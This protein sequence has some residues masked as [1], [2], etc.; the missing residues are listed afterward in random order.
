MTEELVLAEELAREAHAGQVDKSGRAYVHHLERVVSL[1]DG[2]QAQSVA[3]LH[4]VLEDTDITEDELLAE[5][6]SR[7]V[8]AAVQIVTRRAPWDYEEYI[9][10]IILSRNPLAIAV[11]RADLE[12]H[13]RPT[14]PP[15]LRGKYE[16]AWPLI[17][18][19]W[20]SLQR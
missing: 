12:D 7:D 10:R 9:R 8:V 16:A 13:L 5:G 17:N 4:D 6:I 3:W 18:E 2:P 20:A 11:K 1:V 19:A 15:N 14:C